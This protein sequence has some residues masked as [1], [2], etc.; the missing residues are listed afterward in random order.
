[1]ETTPMSNNKRIAINTAV[2]YIK[3]ILSV[4]IGLYTSRVILQ[5]LGASDY[6]LYTIVGGVVS[7][8][9]FLG[10]TMVSVTYRYITVEF[11]KK[12]QG[13]PNRVFNTVMVIHIVLSLF[14]VLI[15]ETGGVY[16]V[17]NIAN[18]DSTK[19]S[20]ALF[21]LHMSVLATVLNVLSIPYN[22]LTI[23]REKFVYTAFVEIGRAIVKLVLVVALS[24]YIGNRLCMFSFIVTIYAAIL[25]ICLFFY[26]I[27]KDKDVVRWNFNRQKE[28]YKGIIQYSFWIMWGAVAYMGQNQGLN[29]IVNLFFNTIINAAFGIGFQI[30]NY[31][32]MFVQSLNQAAVPQI[33]KSQS[34][35]DSNRANS[36]MYMVSKF[37]FFIM[38]L[39][40]VPLI[41]NMDFVLLYWLKEVPP[42]TNIFA[43]LLLLMGLVRS[44]GA[45]FDASI[46]ATGK[47]KPFQLFY[48]IAYLLVLP[49]TYMLFKN[50][51]PVY[52]SIITLIVAAILVLI[53]QAV[54]LSKITSFELLH[55]VKF[56]TMPCVLVLICCLPLYFIGNICP[57]GAAG[58]FY[59]SIVSIIWILAL[60]VFIGLGKQEK[61]IIFSKLSLIRKN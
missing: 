20:D 42:Y 52:T 46:Q 14:L 19:I 43:S 58:F 51:A 25:P 7:M 6:G 57:N 15:A 35:N 48:S 13:D 47:I 23:A 26:C 5:V 11:G 28:D 24:Y 33:M 60:I 30:N 31:V 16:Y 49:I 44:M 12:E 10:T 4:L 45:G 39:L 22:G 59:K 38:L 32:M 3:L 55:Y 37:A 36:L 34:S 27:K 53:F 18:I 41:L 21:V 2:L 56:T 61:K 54:Y 1:M 40:S 17:K 29:M 8:M 50:G 9:N